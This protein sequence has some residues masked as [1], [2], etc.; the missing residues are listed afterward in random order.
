MKRKKSTGLCYTCKTKLMVPS[1]LYCNSCDPLVHTI[2]PIKPLEKT[3][4]EEEKY[5]GFTH[6]LG[7][8]TFVNAKTLVYD[9]DTMNIIGY[10]FE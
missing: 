10:S 7:F 5:M 4:H 9:L 8:K 1:W 2:R 3:E 6:H